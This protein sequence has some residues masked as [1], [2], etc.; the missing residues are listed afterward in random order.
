[1]S[2]CTNEVYSHPDKILQEHLL[3]VA[4][5]SHRIFSN[6]NVNQN[7]LYSHTSFLI[8]LTHDFAKCTSFFQDHLFNN[9][10]S[11]NAYHS[12]LSS[13]LCYY[14]GGLSLEFIK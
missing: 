9:N 10:H 14:K 11:S 7:D 5:N 8:G 6:L 1:M 12:F 3:N 4:E 2:Y 13:I